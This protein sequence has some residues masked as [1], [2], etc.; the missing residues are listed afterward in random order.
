MEDF[1]SCSCGGDLRYV[2]NLEDY[3]IINHPASDDFSN[4]QNENSVNRDDKGARSST[5]IKRLILL[6]SIFLLISVTAAS[7]TKYIPAANNNSGSDQSSLGHNTQGY[8]D[9]YVY[10]G[11]SSGNMENKKIA[12]VTGIHPREPLSKSVM[13]D[14]LKKYP[15]PAGWTVVQYDVNVVKNPDDFTVGRTNGETLAATYIL[16][17]IVKSK[18]ELV[19][20]CHDHKYGYGEGFYFATP[21]MDQG[22]VLF[23]DSLKQNLPNFNYYKNNGK[24]EPG[25][26]NIHFTDP[27]VSKGYKAIVYEM[28]GDTNYS[29]ANA[30]SKQLLDTS[31][32]L[33]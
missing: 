17:D 8:V 30:M 15:V 33:L 18:Y 3:N 5:D 25:S 6:V 27:L 19:I 16:S 2:E 13:T 7:L 11:S 23:A 14:M 21:M 1:S 29:D 24:T 12:I 20:I 10:Q 22:S 9:K 32:K 4:Q 31:L 26:S 28:P